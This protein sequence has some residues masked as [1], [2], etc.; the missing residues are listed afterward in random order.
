MKKILLVLSMFVLTLILLPGDCLAQD[1]R[2]ALPRGVWVTVF[3][4]NKVLY[5]KAETLKLISTCKDAGINEIYLQLYQSGN[6]YYNS[7][8][9]GRQKFDAILKSSGFDSVDFL[10]KE[11]KN[12][13]IKV[14]AWINLMSLGQN[15]DAHILKKF[16]RGV[17]T[18]DQYLR[19][20]G[21]DN[22]N[23][24]DKYYQ[25]EEQ[26]FLEPGDPRVARYLMGVV[27]E[28][29]GRYPFLSGVHLDYVRYPMTL[30]FIPGSRFS[31]FGLTY[32][33]GEEN[34]RL[35]KKAAGLDPLSGLKSDEDFARWDNWR[36]DQVTNIVSKITSR[37]KARHPRMLV[38]CA[39]IPA[40]D[41]AY[42]SLSQDWPLWLEKG[43]VDYVVLMNYTLDNQLAKELSQSALALRQKGKVYFGVGLFLM[44]G[45]QAFPEQNR[46]LD[47]L[48][49]DGV[50][51]FSY[52]DIT[53]DVIANL[54][55]AG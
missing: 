29:T 33:F 54:K 2:A 44:K 38:S 26:L 5:S 1:K 31:K 45:K 18:R 34:I 6:A 3:S 51:F 15:A 42:H 30:P 46:M 41:R 36:R 43:F 4:A 11:A 12:N 13:N 37:V 9:F 28:V 50:V 25:R 17:L 55:S 52:D 35:F 19:P 22:P 8:F 27:D 20:S 49:P 40:F 7:S 39:V 21:R 16:G 24:S 48:Q 14:F 47:S 10:I 53:R 32:G 23:D